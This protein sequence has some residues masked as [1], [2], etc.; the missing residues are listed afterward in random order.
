MS[1]NED[2]S[3]PV[4][5]LVVAVLGVALATAVL[6]TSASPPEAALDG[7]PAAEADR[8]PR[9]ALP[10][11]TD[12]SPSLEPR[13]EDDE[14]AGVPVAVPVGPKQASDLGLGRFDLHCAVEPARRGR[15]HPRAGRPALHGDH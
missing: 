3:P 4:L 10:T 12:P 7:A 5:G 6:Q 14:L 1:K 15:A 11:R 9:R 8:A 2:R 13:E